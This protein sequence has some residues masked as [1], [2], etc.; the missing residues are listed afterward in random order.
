MLLTY[1]DE[2]A[3]RTRYWMG[4]LLCPEHTLI[5][6]TRALDEVVD[7][8]ADEFN[9]VSAQAELHG[10]SLL[11]GEDDWEALK[12]LTRARIGV[13]GRA[14]EAIGASDARII[15]RG[16]NI[17]RLRTR[18]AAPDHPH[19]VT[20]SHL[21]ERVDECADQMGE[22]ALIIADEVDRADTH[23]RRLWTFQR[24]STSGYRSRQL[25]RIVDT[26]H[27]APSQASRLLQAID[28]VVYL[29]QRRKSDGDR[30]GRAQRANRHLWDHVDA[31]VWHD[32]CW[33][34]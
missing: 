5:S 17:P 9:G 1:V 21:L 28:L 16:V 8:A 13:Y 15:I 11:H 32:H 3:T 34:P 22:H 25:T 20:L 26:I 7:K 33:Y 27:F 4:A 14:L 24:F 2:S 12:F 6:L 19:D 10:Y 31:H 18:Y 23:R 30:D 29:Y